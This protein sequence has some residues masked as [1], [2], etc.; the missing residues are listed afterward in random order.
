MG[1]TSW[2]AA[3]R[4][5]GDAGVIGKVTLTWSKSLGHLHIRQSACRALQAVVRR[6]HLAQRVKV[7]KET[8]WDY[9]C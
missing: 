2:Q 9:G 3:L 5:T 6:V 1:D 7:M 8:L 4:S